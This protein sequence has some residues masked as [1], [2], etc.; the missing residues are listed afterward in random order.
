M[1]G[2]TGYSSKGG[3]IKLNYEGSAGQS[4][5]AFCIPGLNLHLEGQANDYVGKSMCG[6]VIAIKPN[7]EF[8]G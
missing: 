7:N 3:I 5:G 6:G 1:H 8:Q 4:F 2:D